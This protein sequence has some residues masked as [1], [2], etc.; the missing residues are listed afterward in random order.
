MEDLK[1]LSL[2]KYITKHS[3]VK[4]LAYQIVERKIHKAL[5][6]EKHFSAMLYPLKNSF[7]KN[8]ILVNNHLGKMSSK[9]TLEYWIFYYCCNNYADKEKMLTEK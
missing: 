9:L 1:K 7:A 8:E 2:L 5:S 3:K 4:R 6:P